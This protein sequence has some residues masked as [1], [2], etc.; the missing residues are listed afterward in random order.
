MGTHSQ[1]GTPVDETI[2]FEV[3]VSEEAGAAPEGERKEGEP[4]AT[5]A[6]AGGPA[7]DEKKAGEEKDPGKEKAGEE[8]PA[9]ASDAGEDPKAKKPG[10]LQKRIDRLTKRAAEAERRAAEAEA[11]LAD[12]KPAPAPK[13]EAKEEPDPE[14]FETY[15]EYLGEWEAWKDAAYGKKPKAPEAK[16]EAKADTAKVEKETPDQE[17]QDAL[18]DV[19][20]AFADT[21]AKHTDFDEVIGAKDLQITR[22]MVLALA[23]AEDPGSIV[24]HLGK[25]KEEAARIAALPPLAQAKEIGKLE[26]LVAK[27]EEAEKSPK[28]KKATAAPAPIEPVGGSDASKQSLDKMSFS[29]YERTM[30]EKEKNRSG[31]FW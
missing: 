6:P 8:V 27:P 30:N 17:F 25:H 12:K 7:A 11:A 24:Y 28:A 29:E 31:G 1:E 5:A 9:A 21:R 4:G 20:E 13:A 22:D 3:V 16:P 18:E 15:D 14:D 19:R 10:R 26:V 23:E 2:N